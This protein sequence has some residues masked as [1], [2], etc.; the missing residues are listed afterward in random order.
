MYMTGYASMKKLTT[1]LW[2]E[3][4]VSFKEMLRYFS[5]EIATPF[6]FEEDLPHLGKRIQ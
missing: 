5:G 4:E 6:R 2:G 3:G 1:L